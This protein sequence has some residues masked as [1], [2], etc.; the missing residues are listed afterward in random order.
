MSRNKEAI[1]RAEEGGYIAPEGIY[2]RMGKEPSPIANSVYDAGMKKTLDDLDIQAMLEKDDP[3]TEGERLL[4]KDVALPGGVG[5]SPVFKHYNPQ[6][7]E[8][9][10]PKHIRAMKDGKAPLEYLIDSVMDDDAWVHKGGADKYGERNWL[11]DHIKA[12][13]YVGAIR[14]HLKAWSEGEDLDPES[15]RPHLSHIRACCAIVLDAKAHGTLIDNRNR[16]YSK[17]I[18]NE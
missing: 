14:R 4:D 12:S 5:F 6:F 2:D 13:T 3:K 9:D 7:E 10:N 18:S 1:K 8:R 11:I 17:D 15:G 16:A